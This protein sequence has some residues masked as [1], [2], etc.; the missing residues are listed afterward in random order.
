[1]HLRV[2]A[3]RAV[4]EVGFLSCDESYTHAVPG[5]LGTVEL[6]ENGVATVFW[7]RTGSVSSCVLTD[8]Q[9]SAE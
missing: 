1:M 4:T 2:T 8:L 3:V 7:D 5:D 9:P 6:V